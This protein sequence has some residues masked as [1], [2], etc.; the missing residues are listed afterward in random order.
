MAHKRLHLLRGL[1]AAQHFMHALVLAAVGCETIPYE[2]SP[3]L[4]S[5][6]RWL[7]LS[8]HTLSFYPS[9]HGLNLLPSNFEKDLPSAGL[10]DFA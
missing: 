5:Y 6:Y 2:T 8:G 3:V 1:L 7:R 4:S 10:K 9:T